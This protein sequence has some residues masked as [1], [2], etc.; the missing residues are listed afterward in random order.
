M[1]KIQE[2]DEFNDPEVECEE[3]LNDSSKIQN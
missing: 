2:E 3:E 1:N